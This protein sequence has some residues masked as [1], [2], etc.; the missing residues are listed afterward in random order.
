LCVLLEA[1]TNHFGLIFSLTMCRQEHLRAEYAVKVK[2]FFL[3]C[4]ILILVATVDWRLDVA[5]CAANPSARSKQGC[6]NEGADRRWGAPV[7]CW[8]QRQL[9]W[10]S[11]NRPKLFRIG[12]LR[13]THIQFGWP[14]YVVYNKPRHDGRWQVFRLGFRYDRNW[15]GYIFPTAAWK[16]MGAAL[17]Y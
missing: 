2:L 15:H 11:E 12:P 9:S 5:R 10:K 16:P 4:A 1:G 8:L 17:E 14:P 7:V 13:R 6:V 3:T